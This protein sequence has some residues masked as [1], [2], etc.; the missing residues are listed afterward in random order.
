M[1]RILSLFLIAVLLLLS[2]APAY[3]AMP[4]TATPYYT[5]TS[6]AG[7]SF[8]ADETGSASWTIICT[9]K[10]S[11]TGIDAVT[12]LERELAG[13]WVRVFIG[14]GNDEFTYSTTDSWMVQTYDFTLR[15]HGTYR[16]VVVFTVH[17]TVEDEELTFWNS[18]TY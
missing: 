4:E 6:Q 3:A 10:S 18:R 17:G 7:V 8:V 2:T 13:T 5:N 1:K 15:N 16:A 12:Y 9:G 11:C 14:N